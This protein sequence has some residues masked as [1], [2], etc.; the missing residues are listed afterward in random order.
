VK[1]YSSDADCERL[2]EL[3]HERWSAQRRMGG[4][5]RTTLPRKDEDARLHPD[6]APY[7]QLTEQTKEYDRA[8]VRETQ[9]ICWNAAADKGAG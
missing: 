4:W 1:L 7:E 5:R 2:A 8:F 9:L 3:E 6:L